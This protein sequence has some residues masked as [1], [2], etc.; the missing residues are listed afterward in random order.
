MFEIM[1]YI[2]IGYTKSMASCPLYYGAPPFMNTIRGIIGY[3]LKI[4]EKVFEL[5]R[6]GLS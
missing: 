3:S 6:E 5:S 1:N 4:T 2:V